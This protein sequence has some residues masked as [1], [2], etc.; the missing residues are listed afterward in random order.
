MARAKE[1]VRATKRAR[2]QALFDHNA[3]GEALQTRRTGVQ[4]TA[5]LFEEEVS[6][7]DYFLRRGYSPMIFLFVSL[8]GGACSLSAFSLVYSI[9]S[10]SA[11][12]R[13]MSHIVTILLGLTNSLPGYG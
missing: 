8:R 1:G 4:H 10:A 11:S 13:M 5:T 6:G 7:A 3:M 9:G 12:S 2:Q